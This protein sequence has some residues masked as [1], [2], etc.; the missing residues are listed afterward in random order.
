MSTKKFFFFSLFT[1]C[2]NEY[3]FR[4]LKKISTIDNGGMEKVKEA[5]KG[6]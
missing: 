6:K 5:M 3:S 2:R 4:S 1:I